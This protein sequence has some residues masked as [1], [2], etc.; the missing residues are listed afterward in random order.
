MNIKKYFIRFSVKV[1]TIEE[2]PFVYARKID[3][4]SECAV[5]E[6]PCPHYTASE[7]SGIGLK[8]H[9]LKYAAKNSNT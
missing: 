3:D 1:L 4:G 8:D 6:I 9:L 2:K 5:E 7:D